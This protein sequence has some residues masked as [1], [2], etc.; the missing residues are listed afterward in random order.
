MAAAH[1]EQQNTAASVALVVTFALKTW[2]HPSESASSRSSG[3]PDSSGEYIQ[4]RDSRLHGNRNPPAA[5]TS[6]S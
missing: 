2:E 5:T 4:R 6:Q 1:S 3:R